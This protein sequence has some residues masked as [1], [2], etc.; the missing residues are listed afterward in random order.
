M[1]VKVDW[2]KASDFAEFK[3]SVLYRAIA[4][5]GRNADGK[6]VGIGGIAF[7][8]IGIP[9]AFSDLTE[10]ARQN[11]IA[12][13][14]AALRLLELAK[15]KNIK[16]LAASADMAASPAAERWLQRLGFNK[17]TIGNI[18]LWIWRNKNG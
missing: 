10:E 14:K 13:H 3:K 16:Q 12:L 17:E 15:S 7:P 4:L 1:T 5:T 18:E 11:P 2:S 9:F 8:N 6:I